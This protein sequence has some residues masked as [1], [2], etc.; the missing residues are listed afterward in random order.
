MPSVNPR[1]TFTASGRAIDA[2]PLMIYRDA[3]LEDRSLPAR[4]CRRGW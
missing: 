4:P 2:E 1:L 3:Q